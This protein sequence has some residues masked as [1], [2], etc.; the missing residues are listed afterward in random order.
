[1]FA[2][3]ISSGAIVHGD[4]TLPW[5]V[6]R[7][8]AHCVWDNN[9]NMTI[10]EGA[11][12]GQNATIA[13][14]DSGIDYYDSNYE[15]FYH[16]DLAGNILGG[17]WY[18]HHWQT[19]I[20]DQNVTDFKDEDGHGTGVAGIVAAVDNTY[21][22][23]GTAPRAKMYAIRHD[24]YSNFGWAKVVAAGIN[25][26]MEVNAQIIIIS[27]ALEQTP[28]YN[29]SVLYNACKNAYGNGSLIF[30]PAGNGNTSVYYPAA[31]DAFVI[32]V[33]AID[34][35]DI[36]WNPS[37]KLGSNFG[38]ELDFV[39]P[40]VNICSTS[41]NGTYT[42]LTGTSVACPHVAAVAAL[43]WSSKPDPE[44]TGGS[45]KPWNNTSV[46]EK[47]RHLALDLGAP[48][49]DDYY[50]YGLINGWAPN[51]RPLGDVNND[52][53]VRVDDVSLAQAAYGS[54]P[55]HSNWDPRADINIDNKVRVDDILII[56][57]NFGKTDP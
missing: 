44:Y 15:R 18:W 20:V 26:A 40:G 41:P 45:N 31:Y 11:N 49:R 14:I 48:G 46:G 28:Y 13:I 30:A 39:A 56:A 2:T 6:E 38:T 55:G 24:Y 33:G 50:G 7:I 36:R 25:W 5:G 43:I 29:Y 4:E 9:H 10:D 51:Q 12:A 22:V 47:L 3:C 23:I 21:G 27:T 32:A 42:N 57:L 8:H 35:N 19:C 17:I 1:M 34:E 37:S 54:E 52:L 53:K 16:P